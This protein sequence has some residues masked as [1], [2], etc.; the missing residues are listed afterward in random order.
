M[1]S[2]DRAALIAVKPRAIT[3]K[4]NQVS[5]RETA[6]LEVEVISFHRES[7]ADPVATA[8]GSDTHLILTRCSRAIHSS[9][10]GFRHLFQHR[11]SLQAILKCRAHK[12]RE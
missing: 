5:N 11:L 2:V 6:I 9:G 8:L 1:M 4:S 3:P 10:F 7:V 12:R